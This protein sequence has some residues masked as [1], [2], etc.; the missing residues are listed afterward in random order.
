VC[1]IDCGDGEPVAWSVGRERIH[2]SCI[3]LARWATPHTTRYQLWKAPAVRQFLQRT[4][5]P[6]CAACLAMALKISLDE[7]REVMRGVDAAAGLQVLSVTCGSCTRATDAL[8]VVRVADRV[9]G[10]VAAGA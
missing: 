1:G 7:V 6:L 5:G 3:D 4:G 10:A 8:C 2:E 9:A